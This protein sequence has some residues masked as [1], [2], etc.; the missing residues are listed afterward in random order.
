MSKMQ[1]TKGRRAQCEL[2]TALRERDWQVIET[3]AGHAVEDMVA[4]SPQGKTYSVECKHCELIQLK[5]FIAQARE[6]AKKRKL[7][8]MLCCRLP[9]YPGMWL[10]IRQD[11]RP[12]VWAG[13]MDVG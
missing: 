7:P 9:L 3:S 12:V 4:I 13:N 5:K 2:A 6:Q 10:V 11:E 8:W 1:R